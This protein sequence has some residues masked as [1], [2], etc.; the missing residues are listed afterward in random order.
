VKGIRRANARAVQ[1]PSPWAG[2]AL[3]A[4]PGGLALAVGLLVYMADRNAAQSMLFPAIAAL[5]TG[6]IFGV[7]GAWLPSFVHPFAFSLFTAALLPFRS[8]W[9]YGACALWCGVNVAFEFGQHPVFKAPLAAALQDGLDQTSL[10]RALASYF[11]LG[12]FDLGD[13]V[14]AALGAIAAAGLLYLLQLLVEDDHAH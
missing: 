12:A 13:L 14:A 6:P 5:G 2:P 1:G 9:R 10:M 8:A 3:V 4:A 11:L 7:T